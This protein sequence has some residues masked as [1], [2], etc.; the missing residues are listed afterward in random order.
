MLYK[1]MKESVLLTRDILRGVNNA[2][3]GGAEGAQ[4]VSTSIK[5]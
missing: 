3:W 2:V 1:P 4:K 5:A